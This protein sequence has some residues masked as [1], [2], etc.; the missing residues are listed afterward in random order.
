VGTFRL[1]EGRRFTPFRY[2]RS[3]RVPATPSSTDVNGRTRSPAVDA[4]S[5]TTTPATEA[6]GE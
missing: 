2:D 1:I 3:S 6:H 5:A 4:D